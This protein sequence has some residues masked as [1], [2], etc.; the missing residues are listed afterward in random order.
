M[1]THDELE[2]QEEVLLLLREILEEA[3]CL[4]V[5]LQTSSIVNIRYWQHDW[6]EAASYSRPAVEPDPSKSK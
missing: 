4:R 3:R 6:G 2:H 1:K 5:M